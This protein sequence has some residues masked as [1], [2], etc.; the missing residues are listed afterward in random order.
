MVCYCGIVITTNI[1]Y[2]DDIYL[3]FMVR[4]PQDVSS[5]AIH[6]KRREAALAGGYAGGPFPWAVAS[7]LEGAGAVI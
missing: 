6:R 7:E 4:S 3:G 1:V 5:F 2:M